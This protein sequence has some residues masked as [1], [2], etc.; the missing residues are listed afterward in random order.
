M[1]QDRLVTSARSAARSQVHVRRDDGRACARDHGHL[2][3]PVYTTRPTG[4]VWPLQPR[5]ISSRAAVDRSTSNTRFAAPLP[6]HAAGTM[7]IVND[8]VC[9]VASSTTLLRPRGPTAPGRGRC[10]WS[11]FDSGRELCASPLEAPELLRAR[12]PCRARAPWPVRRSWQPLPC[13]SV[14]TS[15]EIPNTPAAATRRRV[16]PTP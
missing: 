1:S 15:T 3:E 13:L 16:L 9:G 8:R 10:L 4:W 6:L 2:F 5:S 7:T 11:T 12:V 14:I